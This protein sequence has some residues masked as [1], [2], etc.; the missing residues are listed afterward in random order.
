M[1][2]KSLLTQLMLPIMLPNQLKPKELKPGQEQ[3]LVERLVFLTKFLLKQ[4]IL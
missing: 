2:L 3:P 1:F 4:V